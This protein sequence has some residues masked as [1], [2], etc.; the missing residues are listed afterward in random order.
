MG[1]EKTLVIT[2]DPTDMK[3][4]ANQKGKGGITKEP[5]NIKGIKRIPAY[6]NK[7]TTTDKMENFL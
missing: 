3:K 6:A 4:P 7:F 1:S 5:T 2:T